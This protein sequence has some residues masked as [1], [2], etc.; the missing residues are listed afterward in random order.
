MYYFGFCELFCKDYKQK[1]FS[2]NSV[3]VFT[4][5]QFTFRKTFFF[6]FKPLYAPCML[7]TGNQAFTWVITRAIIFRCKATDWYKVW[8][9]IDNNFT[10]QRWIPKKV[11]YTRTHY[12]Y[13]DYLKAHKSLLI[14]IRT[15]PLSPLISNCHI[16]LSHSLENQNTWDDLFCQKK[17]K[18][19]KRVFLL[20][21]NTSFPKWKYFF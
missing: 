21:I 14:S 18:K 9:W 20:D 3:A 2:V 17:K 8:C 7:A 13:W 4:L 10:R 6:F 11:M 12:L 19:N 16:K 1:M 5:H 15:F